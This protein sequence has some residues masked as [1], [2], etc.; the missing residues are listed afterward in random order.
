MMTELLNS[1]N[2]KLAETTAAVSPCKPDPLLQEKEESSE[3]FIQAVSS[4]HCHMT[5]HITV[6]STNSLENSNRNPRHRSC[7]CRSFR[8]R[9]NNLRIIGAMFLLRIRPLQFP[10]SRPHHFVTPHAFVHYLITWPKFSLL[11]STDW[12]RGADYSKWRSRTYLLHVCQPSRLS[13]HGILAAQANRSTPFV[14]FSTNPYSR[15]FPA[16]LNYHTSF[17]WLWHFATTWLNCDNE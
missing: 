9:Q 8:P 13:F 17:L 15:V 7:Y 11:Q 14:T 12:A 3:L 10:I 1:W 2:L 6:W 5:H 4:T 16:Y